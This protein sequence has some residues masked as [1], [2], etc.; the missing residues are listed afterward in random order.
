MNAGGDVQVSFHV[1]EGPRDIVSSIKIEGADTYP[2]AEFAPD[3]LKL[4][5]GQPYSQAHVQADRANIISHYLES[6]LSQLQFS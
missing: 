2:E 6:G 3:G 4:A 5:A 1:T